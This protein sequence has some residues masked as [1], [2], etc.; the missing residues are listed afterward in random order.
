LVSFSQPFSDFAYTVCRTNDLNAKCDITDVNLGILVSL[1]S[2]RIII[3]SKLLDQRGWILLPPYFGM[4]R[5]FSAIVTAT[6][7]YLYRKNLTDALFNVFI[8]SIV[9][10][11]CC[12]IYADL[13]GDWGLL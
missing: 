2:L 3:N 13:R 5:A 9:I 8:T 12:A 4:F 10:S 11:T 6:I 1:F 7:S